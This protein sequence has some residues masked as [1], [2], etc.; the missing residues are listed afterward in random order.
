MLKKRAHQGKQQKNSD[1]PKTGK[2][3]E[4]LSLKI[5]LADGSTL[6]LGNAQHQGRRP[7]QEDSYGYSELNNRYLLD[8]KGILAVL[9]DG[10]GGLSNGKEVSSTV[11]SRMIEYFNTFDS[12]CADGLN[13]RRCAEHINDG[14]CRVFCPDGSIK[15]G[16]TL[17][18]AMIHGRFLHWLCIGDSRLYIRRKG[19]LYQIN[20]DHDYLN[21][22]LGDA[23]EGGISVTEAFDDPQKDVLVSCL[24]NAELPFADYSLSGFELKKGDKIVLCSDGIYNAIPT[25]LLNS[26]LEN[27]PQSAAQNIQEAVLNQGF[28]TQDNLTIIVISY[29]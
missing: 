21:Q 27:D 24:G 1:I 6:S 28:E 14:I 9:A 3:K 22:L 13:L 17:V 23:I 29:N 19:M 5:E 4:D 25:R 16:S 2:P 15:A 10:M 7:Y 20:E 8:N 26:L 12:V 11:V 18:C